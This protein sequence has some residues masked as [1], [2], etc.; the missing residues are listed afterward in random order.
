MK[1]AFPEKKQKHCV[2]TAALLLSQ[3][4]FW[5]SALLLDGV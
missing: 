5:G 2:P 1:H 3:T 4:A